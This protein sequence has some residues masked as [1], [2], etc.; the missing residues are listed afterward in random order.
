M[1][2]RA[3]CRTDIEASIEAIRRKSACAGRTLGFLDVSD[4]ISIEMLVLRNSIW[5]LLVNASREKPTFESGRDVTRFES[6]D[7]F[8][9]VVT[10]SR[11][12]TA[13]A[14]AGFVF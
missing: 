14:S 3:V 8:E 2:W 5:Q 4:G 6:E 10:A 11:T 7:S 12:A 9:K 1:K 13:T